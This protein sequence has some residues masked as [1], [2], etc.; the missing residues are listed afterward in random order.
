M[1]NNTCGCNA[2]IPIMPPPHTT[3]PAGCHGHVGNNFP[4]IKPAHG[5]YE[6]CCG[7]PEEHKHIPQSYPASGRFKGNAFATVDNNA[8]LIDTSDTSYGPFIPIADTINTKVCQHNVESC[9]DLT[10]TFDMMESSAPNP[11]RL[12]FL[13]GCIANK[14]PDLDGDLPIIKSGFVF[15]V[16][17][18]ILDTCNNE[19]YHGSKET[20]I[21]H[22]T[23]HFTD[24]N[25]VYVQSFRGALIENL[26][27]LDYRGTYYFHIK[28]VELFALVVDTH[29]HY[30][31]AN[32]FYTWADNSTRIIL[33]HDQINNTM[34]D[35]RVLIGTC[36]IEKSFLFHSNITTRFKLTFNAFTTT[37]IPTG[38]T[39]IVWNALNNPTNETI[40]DLAHRVH[41]LEKFIGMMSHKKACRSV[42]PIQDYLYEIHYDDIDYNFGKY[43]LK[44]RYTDFGA[45]SAVRKDNLFGRNYDWYYNHTAYAVVRVDKSI[46]TKYASIGVAGG[47]PEFNPQNIIDGKHPE[48]YGVLPFITLDGINECGVV[49][50]LNVVPSG[51]YGITSGTVPVV[52]HKDTICVLMVVRYI[53]DK[54]ASAKEAVEY[55]RDYVSIYAPNKSTGIQQ[56]IHIMVADKLNTY[57]IEF[58][59]NKMMISDMNIT[60]S[61]RTY[62]TNFYL[63]RTAM[64]DGHIDVNSIT[65]Y[66]SGVE[67]YNIIT[68]NIDDVEDIDSMMRLMRKLNFTNT[69]KMTTNPVWKTEFTSRD[70]GLTVTT[71]L[72]AFMPLIN[73]ARQAYETRMRDDPKTWQTCH[74][75]VYDMEGLSLHLLAQEEASDNVK[76]FSFP[77][78]FTSDDAAK[79]KQLLIDVAELKKQLDEDGEKIADYEKIIA[80]HEKRI[81]KLEQIPL[82]LVPYVPGKEYTAGQL[83]WTHYGALYQ[84]RKNYTASTSKPTADD[85]LEYDASRGYLTQISGGGDVPIDVHELIERIEAMEKELDAFY[86]KDQ[87]DEKLDQKVSTVDGK[88]LSTNDYT[89][90]D[91]ELVH[92]Q[93]KKQIFFGSHLEFPNIGEE[94]VLYVAKDEYMTYIWDNEKQAYVNNDEQIDGNTIQGILNDYDAILL[95]NE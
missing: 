69:Y 73:K 93:F 38:D 61:G 56:E 15:K 80:D 66:G 43:Y 37:Y 86:T 25:E 7:I 62:M 23:F 75:A 29:S 72:S 34:F 3:G 70:L 65:P 44:D 30:T 17:Y 35:R 77:I 21:D 94:D 48:L 2:G 50:N 13:A 24:V 11:A 16:N 64:S 85:N 47:I 52:E 54:F 55:L 4:F 49:A 81:T 26:C 95:N 76:I 33:M 79:I 87:L 22:S 67:R 6:S 78:E 18:T 88:G 74:N 57:I 58:I 84:V 83:T 90:E 32:P 1:N 40:E 91:K 82:A 14:Y 41:D 51:D 71:P 68:D 31:E 36:D 19:L 53:L 45:C 46:A 92:S 5:M 20:F 59:D 9:I 89:D 28:N 27:N 12:N 39:S 63:F 10:A 42:V 8:Y 60:Y